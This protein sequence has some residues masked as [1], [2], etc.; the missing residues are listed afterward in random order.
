MH[1]EHVDPVNGAGL[2]ERAVVV[3]RGYGMQVRRRGSGELALAADSRGGQERVYRPQV[4]GRLTAALAAVID[5]DGRPPPL[6]VAP[7][8]AGSVAQVLRARGV[9]YVD[10]AGNAFLHGDGLL[11]DVRGRK[12]GKDAVE[13]GPRA[14]NRP[15]TR[16]GAQ[17]TFCLL[18]WPELAGRPVRDVAAVSGVSLGSVHAVHRDLEGAGYVLPGPDGRVLVRAG[19]LLDR[20]VEAYALSLSPSLHL[21]Y[22]RATDPSWWRDAGEELRAAAVELGGEAAAGV[23]DD[24]LRPVTSTLYSKQ[25]PVP[26]LAR[27]RCRRAES[28][29][30]A[31]VVVRRRFWTPPGLEAERDAHGRTG[32]GLVPVVLVY[33]DLLISGESSQQEHAR[34][35][36]TMDDRLTRLDRS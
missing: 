13:P 5:A 1:N 30:E 10:L 34:R 4:H 18:A 14:L 29:E 8:V 6:V 28:A 31:D 12:P 24:R 11:V 17:V 3:L 21:G 9:D 26:L 16:S 33:A 36:R 35:L 20:W 7:F 25:V 22:Y 19:E 32:E 2:L 15:F 23:L 27:Y